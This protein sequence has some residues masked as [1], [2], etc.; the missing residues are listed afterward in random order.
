MLD[1][2]DNNRYNIP[3]SPQSLLSTSR[4]HQ[5]NEHHFQTL[6]KDNQQQHNGFFVPTLLGKK[7]FVEVT[8]VGSKQFAYLEIVLDSIRDICEAGAFVSLHI[9]TTNCDPNA[10]SDIECPLRGQ[11]SEETVEDN[12]PVEI[13]DHLNERLRCRNPE[14]TLDT[15]IHLLSPD[16]GKQVVDNHRRLF[17]DNID[18][19]YDVFIHTEE[20]ETIRPTNVIAFLHETEKLRRLVGNKRLGDYSIGFVRYEN[21]MDH[22]EKKRVVWEFEW[23]PDVELVKHPGIEGRYFTSPPW[24]HQ[25]MFM[26]TRLQL[27]AWKTREPDCHFHKVERRPGYHTERISGCLD[28]YDVEYCNVTQL[29][30]LDSFEDFLIHHIPDKN[31]KRSPQNIVRTIDLHKRRMRA[32]HSD[33]RMD[34]RS[35]NGIKMYIDEID[36]NKTVHFNLTAYNNYVQRGGILSEE[37]LNEYEWIIE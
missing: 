13:I 28:L 24:H 11:T 20:D 9:T 14:G 22:S 29:L 19:G 1:E 15:H 8:T 33:A 3:L 16:W 2:E 10:S 34:K 32:L 4:Q 5:S 36:P 21:E 37:E 12:F 26:A 27:L 23:D 25:G 31:H 18:E 30:P 35:Y 6:K 7:I 17:Y